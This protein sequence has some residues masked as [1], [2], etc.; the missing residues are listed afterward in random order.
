[1]NYENFFF[2]YED[3]YFDDHNYK[4][5]IDKLKVINEKMLDKESKNIFT[6]RIMYSLT[7]DYSYIYNIVVNTEQGEKLNAKLESA[8]GN[9]IYIFGA[10]IRGGRIAQIFSDI[11]WR[12]F[13]DQ[14]KTGSYVDLPIIK[15]EDL[16]S[17]GEAYLLISNQFGVEEIKEILLRHGISEDHIFTLD[18]FDKE[19]AKKQYFE[20]FIAERLPTKGGGYIDGGGYDG[21]TTLDY[22][23]IKHNCNNEIL[24]FEPD[25]INYQICKQR[26]KEYPSVRIYPYALSDK[27]GISYFSQ[28]GEKSHIASDGNVQIETVTLDR[29][30]YNM[31]VDFIKLDVEGNET[32]AI[33]GSAGII[34]KQHP[35]CAVCL[36]HKKQDIW[37]IP[38]LLLELNP[39]YMFWL[40]HYSVGVTD[41]ILYAVD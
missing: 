38:L 16:Q 41:T 7:E 1:M 27:E 9:A 31:A 25:K 36:Y 33:L 18:Q 20:E 30:A 15:L 3:N 40:R 12:G 26:L 37:T 5:L 19:A 29:I 21:S 4:Y 39:D 6:N 22:L 17:P 2:P 10:G 11:P 13:V 34:K 23:R 28:A 14:R 35:T 24:V 8:H 32:E